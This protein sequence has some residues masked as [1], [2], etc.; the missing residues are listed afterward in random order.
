[1]RIALAVLLM[2]TLTLTACQSRLNPFNWFGNDQEVQVDVDETA[3]NPLVPNSK[4]GNSIFGERP[5]PVYSGTIVAQVKSVQVHRVPEGAM[6]EVIGISS[7]HGAHTVKLD[8]QNGGLPERGVLTYNLLAIHPQGG[9]TGGPEQSREI[10]VAHILTPAQL[11][12]VRTIRVVAA[13]NAR[14]TR[15]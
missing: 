12:G 8:P 9:Y 11:E 13:T 14:E 4:G 1:M 10:S 15:R 3:V 5:E 2:S 6:I 7:I